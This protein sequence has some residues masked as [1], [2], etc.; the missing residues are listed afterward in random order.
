VP[1]L[2]AVEMINGQDREESSAIPKYLFRKFLE[3]VHIHWIE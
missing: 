3:R 1:A 2:D